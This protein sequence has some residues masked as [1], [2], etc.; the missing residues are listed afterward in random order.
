MNTS[1]KNSIK[2]QIEALENETS[3]ESKQQY[4]IAK[5]KIEALESKYYEKI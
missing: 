4:L 2:Q 5:S 1:D 3:N